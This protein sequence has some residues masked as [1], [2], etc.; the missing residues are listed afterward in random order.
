MSV[1][2][3][4][5][6]NM[7]I[8]IQAERMPDPGETVI[9]GDFSTQAGG[10]GG[11]QAIAVSRLGAEASMLGAV[12]ND[13]YGVQLRENLASNN[14]HFFGSELEN[15][16]TGVAVIV[17][18]DGDNRIVLNAGANEGVTPELVKEN[19]K[20]FETA[21]HV[22]MQLEIPIETVLEAS[23]LAKKHGC[24]VV[25]NPAPYRTMP[26]E[27]FQYTDIIVPNEHEAALLIGCEISDEKVAVSAVKQIRK[28]GVETVIITLG[29]R[30]C[31]YNDDDEL[32]FCDAKETDCI[33]STAAGDTFIGGLI[34]MLDG[35]AT[36]CNAIE[37]ASSAAAIA[38]SRRGATN[39]IPTISE[40][41]RIHSVTI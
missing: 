41:K 2:V 20:L 39:S 12:G 18:S 9:G 14:I 26:K 40:V 11:N 3:I 24:T 25:I 22:V 29:D 21:D 7:D 8:S 34:A 4:G 6:L 28:M 32:R 30:G 31:V 19:E 23:R 17:V 35:G 15:I 38:V 36:L 27:L 13:M 16:P 33:D 1:L 5:S 37:F 10:K